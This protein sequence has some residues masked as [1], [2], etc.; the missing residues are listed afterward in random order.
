MAP[1]SL[2][3]WLGGGAIVFSVL[4]VKE[5]LFSSVQFS[6]VAQLVQL[7]VTPKIIVFLGFP[8]PGPL[9]RQQASVAAFFLCV[10]VGISGL[11]ASSAPSMVYSRKFTPM[12]FLGSQD[13]WSVCL[14]SASQSLPTCVLFIY[15]A[16]QWLN[17]KESACQCGSHRRHG[18]SSW[19]R[20]IP[21]RRIRYSCLG[22]SM[23][24]GALQTTVHGVTNSWTL[25]E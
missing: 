4:L 3:L 15:M 12:S 19:A 8:F 22:H 14:L 17:G 1:H 23:D 6:S 25:T 2:L 9:V 18:F 7:F 13:S 24:R 5:G 10:S 20:K 21:W 11:W 16:S